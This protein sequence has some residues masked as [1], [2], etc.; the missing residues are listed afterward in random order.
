MVYF[1]FTTVHMLNSRVHFIDKTM[2]EMNVIYDFWI[3]FLFQWEQPSVV[4]VVYDVTSETSF[5]SCAKWLERVKSRKPEVSIP[6]SVNSLSKNRL[7][8]YSKNIWATY[9]NRKFKT[10]TTHTLYISTPKSETWH[11]FM[12]S[13]F[14]TQIYQILATYFQWDQY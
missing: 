11:I 10:L 7:H 1:N 8:L 2:K 4:M 12:F 3:C 5:S 13:H 6:G 9:L 14:P